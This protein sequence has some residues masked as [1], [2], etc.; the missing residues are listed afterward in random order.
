MDFRT[1]LVT[2]LATAVRS[3]E[4]S[5]QTLVAHALE[6]IETTNGTVNA[7]VAVAA[8]RALDDAANLD[9]RIRA[10]EDVGPLA[11]IPI[12][13]KDLEDAAGLPTTHGA[14][15]FRG[16]PPATVDSALVARLRAAGCIVVGKTN[17]P[18]FGW[19]A[20]TENT[21]FG[22]TANPWNLDHT[23]AGSSG[24]SAAALAAGMVPLATGSDGGGSIRIPASACGLVGF[25][26]SFGR[27]PTPEG[28]PAWLDLSSKGPMARNLGDV[29]AALN[30]VLGPDPADSQSL[31]A[32][33]AP[34]GERLG[35]PL[36]VVW[37]E[38][39]GH[40]TTDAEVVAACRRTLDALTDAGAEIV[41]VDRVFSVDP[42]DAWLTTVGACLNRSFAEHLADPAYLEVDAVL[43]LIVAGGGAVSGR[44][45]LYAM[46]TRATLTADL[47]ATLSRSDVL[48][49][50]TTAGVAP[51]LDLGGLGVVNG[52]ETINWVQYTYGFN[53][54]RSPAASMPIGLSSEGIPIGIQVVA[55]WLADDLVLEG[56]AAIDAAVPF[57]A[58]A[59]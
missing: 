8:E 22:R 40:G 59:P 50:P 30:V 1:D 43:Q 38:D 58:V 16:A 39:L 15:I 53:L 32:P 11:G 55:N 35:R 14:A 46:D 29:V 41:E 56:C 42:F 36:R 24:G 13:V 18:E 48:L 31:P 51:R 4:V 47:A 27:I 9:A 45:L 26:P 37:S 6:T 33:T 3:G 54:T 49:C 12:G 52:E 25:K 2:D 20:K 34:L 44:D 21:L 23:P 5:A 17:T 7:F 10:G 19:T 57:T 28:A